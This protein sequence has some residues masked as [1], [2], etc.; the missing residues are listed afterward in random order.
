MDVFY[1]FIQMLLFDAVCNIFVAANW[2]VY[3]VSNIKLK[4]MNVNIAKK[5]L[6]IIYY[7]N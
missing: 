6:F 2:H 4:F 1:D 3:I 7:K 5:S